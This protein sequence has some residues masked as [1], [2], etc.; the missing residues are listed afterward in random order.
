M[1][2][3]SS[4]EAIIL[5]ICFII[6]HSHETPSGTRSTRKSSTA[7]RGFKGR[8]K[9]EL[10]CVSTSYCNAIPNHKTGNFGG[11]L[12]EQQYRTAANKKALSRLDASKPAATQSHTSLQL[13][14]PSRRLCGSARAWREQAKITDAR[15]NEC[16][17]VQFNLSSNSLLLNT[18]LLTVAV[19][20]TGNSAC[21]AF[22]LC[23]L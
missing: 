18:G 8:R 13:S 22:A 15:I 1:S 4:N 16:R 3:R 5:T 2:Q 7:C 23:H 20:L 6:E 17:F 11:Q 19:F 21:E 10:N 12:D 14:C 9:C